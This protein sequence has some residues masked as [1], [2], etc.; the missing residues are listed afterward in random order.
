MTCAGAM[1]DGTRDG[2]GVWQGG[3][4]HQDLPL[5]SSET[6]ETLV[7]GPEERAKERVAELEALVYAYGVLKGVG[8]AGT[9]MSRAAAITLEALKAWERAHPPEAVDPLIFERM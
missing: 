3:I 5:Y 1:P 7:R 2:D 9:T 8:P 6:R 4:W